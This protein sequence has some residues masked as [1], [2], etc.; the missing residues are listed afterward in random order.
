MVE[1]NF[2]KN[3]YPNATQVQAAAYMRDNLPPGPDKK[4]CN[5]VVHATDKK[6]KQPNPFHNVPDARKVARPKL[7]EI[8]IKHGFAGLFPPSEDTHCDE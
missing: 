8:K 1:S 7:N 4:A 3:N 6:Q 2:I 5:Q